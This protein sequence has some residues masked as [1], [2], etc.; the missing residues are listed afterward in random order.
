MVLERSDLFS[1]FI[2]LRILRRDK[3]EEFVTVIRSVIIKTGFVKVLAPYV[4]ERLKGC[5]NTLLFQ[6]DVNDAVRTVSVK[7]AH[8]AAPVVKADIPW[9]LDKFIVDL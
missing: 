6:F 5:F 9:N 4:K 2:S 3:H 7:L 8:G 1:V